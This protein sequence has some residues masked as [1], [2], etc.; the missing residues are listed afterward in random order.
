MRGRMTNEPIFHVTPSEPSAVVGFV[1]MPVIR[2]AGN[3]F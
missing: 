3:V 2:K 1:T